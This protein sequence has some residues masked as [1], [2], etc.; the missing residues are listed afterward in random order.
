MKR[1]K[2]KL[3]KWGLIGA[4]VLSLLALGI[5]TGAWGYVILTAYGLGSF[6]AWAIRESRR[7]WATLIV[8][9]MLPAIADK[10]QA[11]ESWQRDAER[12]VIAEARQFERY[13]LR[14]NTEEQLYR[15]G[16]DA[17]GFDVTPF[18]TPF[19]IQIKQAKGQPTDRVTLFD[20]GQF[21]ASFYVDWRDT[22]FEIYA[23]DPLTPKLAGKYGPDIFGLDDNSR[24]DLIDNLKGPLL[25]NLKKEIL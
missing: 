3:K 18:Y 12:H 21:H 19:T 8:L 14:S 9:L 16:Q 22:E 20:T 1:I 4:G 24:R 23:R 15:R 11:L 6:I 25:E 10:I 5:I 2:R 7:Q 13:I 17:E